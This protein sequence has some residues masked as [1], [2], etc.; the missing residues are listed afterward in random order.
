[1]LYE[2]ILDQ[3][4]SN[5]DQINRKI[6]LIEEAKTSGRTTS[7]EETAFLASTQEPYSNEEICFML[8]AKSNRRAAK[9]KK[10]QPILLNSQ[11]TLNEF[12]G[13]LA[14]MKGQSFHYDI[15]LKDQS[16]V[17]C[18]PIQINSNGNEISLFYVDAVGGIENIQTKE[19]IE[20]ALGIKA[21][22]N[23]CV[24]SQTDKFSCAIFSLKDLNTMSKLPKEDLR[25]SLSDDPNKKLLGDTL[26]EKFIKN[27]Q[28]L[29][30]ASKYNPNAV[31][32]KALTLSQYIDHYTVT[33]Q[34]SEI[35][36][37][38]RNFAILYKTKQYLEY[39]I[40][41]LDHLPNEERTDDR[42]NQITQQR[43][44]QII[45]DQTISSMNP[46][47]REMANKFHLVNR[48]QIELITTFS[49]E[50]EPFITPNLACFQNM[51]TTEKIFQ[52]ITDIMNSG[53][54][55][56]NN[57]AKAV[58]VLNMVKDFSDINQINAILEYNLDPL[59]VTEAKCFSGA[60][61]EAIKQIH[62]AY[63]TTDASNKT[64]AVLATFNQIKD[65]KDENTIRLIAEYGINPNLVAKTNF[66]TNKHLE[67]GN[68][69]G[70]ADEALKFIDQWYKKAG[71]IGA[72][73][74]FLS[75]TKTFEKKMT[76]LN[77]V[78]KITNLNSAN[79]LA[80]RFQS[81]ND[82]KLASAWKS[83]V[84]KEHPLEVRSDSSDSLKENV[85]PIS[86]KTRASNRIT[87][88]TT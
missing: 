59:I 87:N 26:N 30:L 45:I 52:K 56:E 78:K 17:H 70:A 40:E 12:I 14:G 80:G 81:S 72:E 19:K 54:S 61:D 16:G 24:G 48:R 50:E 83:L 85:I 46:S 37:K 32:S 36:S 28:S 63:E 15:I 11:D 41:F 47:A 7:I 10:Y 68:E 9:G 65:C 29:S 66:I 62:K 27:S 13:L 57:K 71:S 22:Q 74:A 43:L 77:K 44:G 75:L 79:Q 35:I 86:P 60:G 25:I 67:K 1:M 2:Q 82:S 51:K 21:N 4:N 55:F 76:A 58:Q 84:L 73:L 33:T 34:V 38:K 42:I 5:L 6:E 31:V 8:E 69:L 3:L 53:D 20:N 23:V 64:Q 88:I 18:T 49:L 39:A